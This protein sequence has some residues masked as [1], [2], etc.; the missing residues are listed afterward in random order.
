[1]NPDNEWPCIEQPQPVNPHPITESTTNQSNKPLLGHDSNEVEVQ[2]ES[3][4]E[5]QNVDYNNEN[6]NESHEG[7]LDI[8]F[9][10]Y[11]IR[12]FQQKKYNLVFFYDLS[13]LST[14]KSNNGIILFYNL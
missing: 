3:S 12:C 6:E 1:M 4:S 13:Y 9:Q 5:D 11:N 2:D 10:S 8:F 14:T 7:N